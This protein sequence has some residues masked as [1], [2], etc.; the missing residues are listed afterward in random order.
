MFSGHQHT[1]P[2]DTGYT[3]L[4]VARVLA[5]IDHGKLELA[6]VMAYIDFSRLQLARVL[7]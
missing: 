3:R 6:R 4:E 2:P 1:V 7:A 5:Y